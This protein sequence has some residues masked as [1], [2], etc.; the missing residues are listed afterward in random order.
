MH[1][2]RSL[3]HIC[4]LFIHFIYAL[5][6]IYENS[7][8]KKNSASFHEIVLK[9]IGVCNCYP[10]LPECHPIIQHENTSPN[11]LKGKNFKYFRVIYHISKC[12]TPRLLEVKCISTTW[13]LCI[14]NTNYQLLEL[15][16]E[17]AT[18]DQPSIL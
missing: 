16:K 18:M 7:F 2:T 17:E 6:K 4:D 8:G 15:P 10:E 13:S 14:A 3:S 9:N 11:N 12:C 1:K 5:L